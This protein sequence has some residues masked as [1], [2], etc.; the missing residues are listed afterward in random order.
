MNLNKMKLLWLLFF[1][2]LSFN[3]LGQACG[4]YEVKYKGNI[5]ADVVIQEVRFPSRDFLSRGI[6][7]PVK[8]TKWV[9]NKFQKSLSGNLD[10]IIQYN[11]CSAGASAKIRINWIKKHKTFLPL[12]V[13][14][15]S[16]KK[17]WVKVPINQIGFTEAKE[18]ARIL[19]IDFKE[20]KI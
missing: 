1:T 5:K 17:I 20:I 19:E 13:I 4:Y 9:T 10:T 2:S 18:D 11:T 8:R 7:Q 16:E 12:L 3:V 15:K 6:E 14:T